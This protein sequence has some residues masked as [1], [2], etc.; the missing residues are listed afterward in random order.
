MKIIY[1]VTWSLLL[2]LVIIQQGIEYLELLSSFIPTFKLKYYFF[3]FLSD[4]IFQIVELNFIWP[5]KCQTL[6]RLRQ[7]FVRISYEWGKSSHWRNLK[8]FSTSIFYYFSPE[9]SLPF[10][11]YQVKTK[12][13][14]KQENEILL[15]FI[16]LFWSKQ[17]P[18]MMDCILIFSLYWL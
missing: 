1:E 16:V 9:S 17:V 5:N 4:E 11:C 10:Y 3:L 6:T 18:G 8:L 14:I 2:A 7:F 12:S 15:T 13:S